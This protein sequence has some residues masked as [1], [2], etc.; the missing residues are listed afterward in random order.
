MLKRDTDCNRLQT[1][2]R[3]ALFFLLL[4]VVGTLTIAFHHH[5]DDSD[6]HDCPVCAAGHHHSAAS[7]NVFSIPNQQP[8]SSNEFFML[9]L[10][11]D[12]ERVSLLPCRAPPV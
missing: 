5:D 11:F 9:S 8:I 4:F 6:H 7:I 10:P 12:S 2:G 1:T 3:L